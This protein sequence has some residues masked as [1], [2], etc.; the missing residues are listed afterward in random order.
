MTRT[1]TLSVE[2]VTVSCPYCGELYP[3]PSGS[4][5]WTLE[6]FLRASPCVVDC[7]CGK[8]FRIE[9]RKTAHFEV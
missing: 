1:A 9:H 8:R 5:M 6:D 3:S 7:C 4:H 2:A